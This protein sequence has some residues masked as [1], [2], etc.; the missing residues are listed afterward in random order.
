MEILR[1]NIR[2]ALPQT[3]LRIQHS[4]VDRSNVVPAQ[5]HNAHTQATSN[6]GITQ[7]TLEI[8]SYESRRYYGARTLTDL[9]REFAQKGLSDVK[10][11]TSKRTQIM[12]SRAENGGKPGDDIQQQIDNEVKVDPPETLVNFEIMHGVHITATPSEVVGEPDLGDVTDEI[13]TTP[14]ADLRGTPASVQTY[15]KDGGF[16]RRWVSINNYDIY[17]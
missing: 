13:E 2:H 14:F 15:L 8:D 5:L 10:A 9:T 11:G 6:K 1:L 12:W 3:D 7:S 4:R 17:A 16:I